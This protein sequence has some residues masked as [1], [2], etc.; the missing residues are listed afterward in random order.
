MYSSSPAFSSSSTTVL[1]EGDGVNKDCRLELSDVIARPCDC[2]V[3]EFGILA[4]ESET[5]W[6]KSLNPLKATR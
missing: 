2:E 1:V 4:A 5:F 3:E 6:D